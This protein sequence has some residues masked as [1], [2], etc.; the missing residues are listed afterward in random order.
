M[1]I[2][3]SKLPKIGIEAFEYRQILSDM[4]GDA[5]GIYALYKGD[6]LYYIGKAIDLKRRLTQHLKDQHQKKWDTFSLFMINDKKHIGDLESLLI[7]IC[8]PKGNIAHP[9]S[10]AKDL[11]KDFRNRIKAYQ[12]DK[13][14]LIFKGKKCAKGKKISLAA[15]YKGKSFSAS[16]DCKEK[17]VKLNGKEYSS[18]SAAAMSVTGH[19]TNGLIFWKTKNTEGIWVPLK[20]LL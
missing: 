14:A 20:K 10:R 11:T 19:S 5:S 4:L 16:F 18:P 17:T 6:K 2:I 7:T 8:E 3:T 12:Q 15:T 1:K 13:N 9:K